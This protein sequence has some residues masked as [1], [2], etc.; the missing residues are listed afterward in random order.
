[1]TWTGTAADAWQYWHYAVTPSTRQRRGV[2]AAAEHDPLRPLPGWWE[3]M[4]KDVRKPLRPTNFHGN[5]TLAASSVLESFA[6][7]WRDA[8]RGSGRRRLVNGRLWVA[9]QC[10][11]ITL[12]ES[13][14]GLPSGPECHLHGRTSGSIY[15]E[16]G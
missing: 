12:A 16:Y 6:V 4:S 1:M 8:L 15:R 7:T 3:V 13:V 5:G 11:D 9:G 14:P 10:S 2:A